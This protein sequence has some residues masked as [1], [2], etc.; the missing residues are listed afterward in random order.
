[1]VA[2]EAVEAVAVVVVSLP[3]HS[4]L[5]RLAQQVRHFS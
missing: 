2:Q 5:F 3:V 4:L 1:M